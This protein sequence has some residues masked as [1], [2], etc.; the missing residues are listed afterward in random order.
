M[1]KS[2][3]MTILRDVACALLAR[4]VWSQS[5][6][7]R[8]LLWPIVYAA[9]RSR[10]CR[11][12]LTSGS[13]AQRIF[14]QRAWIHDFAGPWKPSPK[15]CAKLLAKTVSESCYELAWEARKPLRSTFYLYRIHEVPESA[16]N[17]KSRCASTAYILSAMVEERGI[18]RRVRISCAVRRGACR[19]NEPSSLDLG[20][21]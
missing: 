15:H 5:A 12:R 1:G 2:T 11:V 6:P 19:Q 8:A 7:G 14:E 21:V 16:L 13:A 3:P 20:G 4:T 17:A 10:R 9:V 18:G